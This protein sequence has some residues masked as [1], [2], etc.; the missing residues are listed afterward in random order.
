MTDY[1]NLEERLSGALQLRRRPVAVSFRETPPPT[2][3]A[4]TG[5]EAAGC[6]F[7]RL[8]AEG[9]TFYTI[10]SDHYNCAIG[11]YTHSI[12]LPAER[13]QELDQTLT[14]MNGLG[15]VSMNEIPT[16]LRLSDTPRVVI[17]APL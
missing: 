5:T 14:L 12:N 3:A 1:H 2:V 15:Y 6:G 11:S 16:V 13:A 7:W 10:P 8:A 9:R 17:Y 4:F